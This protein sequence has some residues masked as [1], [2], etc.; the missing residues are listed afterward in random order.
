VRATVPDL[1]PVQKGLPE[2]RVV[3]AHVV[4]NAMLPV[5]TYGG[6]QF[7]VLMSG[8][9][10]TE[11]V[12]AIPGLGKLAIDSVLQRDRNMVQAVVVLSAASFILINWL[13]DL[14]Y[15]GFG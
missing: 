3:T 5:I 2:W 15:E 14:I 1:C 12:F 6:L 10:I 9:A 11:S 7:G 4:K 8:A 13:T